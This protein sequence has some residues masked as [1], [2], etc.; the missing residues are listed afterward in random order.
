MYIFIDE[1]GTFSPNIRGQHSISAVGALVIP[2]SAMKSFDKLYTR[3]RR[4]LPKT[5]SEVKGRNL[6][7]RQVAEVARMLRKIGA[8]FEVVAVDMGMHSEED[9]TRH[10]LGQAE[11][12]TTHLTSKHHPNL[13]KQ[14]WELRRNLE[15]MSLQLY[16]QS[17]AMGA[18]V[19]Q[20]LKHADIYYAF[21]NPPELGEYHWR[22][23]GKD[24]R[25]ITP[26]EKWWST[27]ILPTLES[28]TFRDPLIRAAEGDYRWQER[29][30]TRPSDY[31]LRFVNDPQKGEFCNLRMVM[32]EDFRFSADPEFGLEAVDIVTNTIRRSLSGNFTRSGWMEIRQLMIHR[33]SHYI[34]LISLSRESVS[35]HRIPYANVIDDFRHGGRA[36]FPERYFEE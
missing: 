36:M 33:A 29:F 35:S 34:K 31:K 12:I 11:A 3:L 17:V 30:R 20:T 19:Y 6:S 23:D 27:V 22:I 5:K 18:L 7:E 15:D 8:L 16:V 2:N 24:R 32:T 10:R 21:R 14:V 13:V 28:H 4:R 1:S 26:W 9:L 25:G